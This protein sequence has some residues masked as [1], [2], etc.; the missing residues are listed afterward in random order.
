MRYR[1][2]FWEQKSVKK[3]YEMVK[4]KRQVILLSLSPTEQAIY[5]DLGTEKYRYNPKADPRRLLCTKL[6]S[7]WGETLTEVREYW[8]DVKK[9]R[10]AEKKAIVKELEKGFNNKAL[11]EMHHSTRRAISNRFERERATVQRII[12]KD[13]A[14]LKVYE[15]IVS[16]TNNIWCLT[17]VSHV[18]AGATKEAAKGLVWMAA[19]T[20]RHK[21]SQ[22]DSVLAQVVRERWNSTCH[23][24]LSGTFFITTVF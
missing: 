8:K 5:N 2:N 14:L 3:E 12:D 20:V 13:K 23:C 17:G 4:T 1:A 6:D 22:L 16:V 19:R 11:E 9:T 7:A 21:D 15:A 24:V 18:R 10:I